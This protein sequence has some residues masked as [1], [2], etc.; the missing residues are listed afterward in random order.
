MA[1]LSAHR[2]PHNGISDRFTHGQPHPS[3]LFRARER[4]HNE[5]GTGD[6]G[7]PTLNKGEFTRN[8]Q[9]MSRWEHVLGR[10][11]GAALGAPRG[12]DGPTGTRTHPQ[13]E[14]VGLG[15]ATDVGLEGALH[16]GAPTR[17]AK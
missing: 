14:A 17:C 11:A 1:K 3:G 15:P 12:E 5:S 2:V 7:T 4:A 13:S 9:P 10:Q 16:G 8:P 6:S